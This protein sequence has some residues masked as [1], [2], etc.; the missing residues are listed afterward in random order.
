MSTRDR[1][2]AYRRRMKDRGYR[3]IRIWVPDMRDEKFRQY[4][5]E[6]AQ[7]INEADRKDGIMD[8]LEEMAA[9]LPDDDYS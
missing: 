7:Q 1:V 5:R 4:C 2:A 8:E 9:D 6:S 3:E